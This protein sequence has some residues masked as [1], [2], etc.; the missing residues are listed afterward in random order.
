MNRESFLRG[1]VVPV[2]WK[3]MLENFAILIKL[4]KRNVFE[5]LLGVSFFAGGG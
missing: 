3:K 2:D 4:E 5:I 1:G